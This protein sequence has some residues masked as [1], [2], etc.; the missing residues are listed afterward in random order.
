[1]A[2]ALAALLLLLGTGTVWAQ[3][4]APSDEYRELPGIGSRLAVWMAAQ[5]HLLFAAF[6][7]AVPMFAGD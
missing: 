3:G 4:P 2:L 7:L 1:M 6:V 5:L